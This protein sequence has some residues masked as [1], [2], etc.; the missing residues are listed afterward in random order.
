MSATAEMR[1]TED[2]G[3]L[4]FNRPAL[5]LLLGVP[6]AFI[7]DSGEITPELARSGRR[8]LKEYQAATG[9]ANPFIGDV[10][11]YYAVRQGV[12]VVGIAPDGRRTVLVQAKGSSE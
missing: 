3:D 11:T 8:R 2:G 7:P 10:V 5:A 6:A 1:T 4:L 9:E 12:E